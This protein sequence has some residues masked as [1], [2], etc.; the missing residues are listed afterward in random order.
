[1]LRFI[2]R[3]LLWM[4]PTLAILVIVLFVLTKSIPGDPVL[5]YINDLQDFTAEKDL[6]V[7]NQLYQSTAEKIGLDRPI[8]YFSL[9]PASYGAAYFDLPVLEQRFSKAMLRQH[10]TWQQVQELLKHLRY[11]QPDE[12]N[13]L[14]DPK[15]KSALATLR[16]YPTGPDGLIG[17]C[18]D[19]AST[20]SAPEMR[21]H[22]QE[23]GNLSQQVSIA[24]CPTKAYVPRLIWHGP[25]NQFH[26][27]LK[28]ALSF[29]LGL[30]RADGRPATVKIGEALRWTVFIN[31]LSI[32]LA[33]VVGILLGS[34]A[35][36]W[37]GVTDRI[38]SVLMY[39]FYAIP[40]FWLTTILVVFFS[41]SEYG[42]WTHIFPATGIWQTNPEASFR[43]TIADNSSQLI[44]PVLALSL[45]LTAFVSRQIKSS[46]VA[47]LG[48]AYV[49]Q[50]R[51]FGVPEHRIL[52]LQVFRNAS[53]PL[54]TLVA[55]L[56]P[57][58]ISG[59]LIVEVICNIPGMGRLM[60][61]AIFDK[62]WS[63]VLGVVLISGL[64]TMLGMLISD[65]CYK[66]ANPQVRF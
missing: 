13:E 52:W 54:I 6:V 14:V 31:L 24:P 7:S 26:Q 38:A 49:W 3:R 28:A 32:L 33:F 18:R 56:F 15:G 44:I 4:L 41:T 30:S 42:S 9:V 50:A 65:L 43:Q 59:S 57:A 46:V 64:L 47:E 17:L 34:Y 45:H 16:N 48:K 21:W 12:L 19:L 20:S 60:Y 51:S 66:W 39:L 25:D 40:I 22:A 61:E 8:F 27:W 29:D 62:D 53:T 23:I 10:A 11:F 63:I 35:G 36:W 58:A 55:Y 2:V 5:N 1:M 37:G